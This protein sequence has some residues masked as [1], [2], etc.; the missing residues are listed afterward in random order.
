MRSI[1]NAA[2]AILFSDFLYN[3]HMLWVLVY[4]NEYKT[5][6]VGTHLICL[7]LSRQFK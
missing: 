1:F 5:Y 6:V 3:K 2:Y 7:D 4:S